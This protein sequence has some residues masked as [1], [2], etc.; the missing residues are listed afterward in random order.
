MKLK[1]DTMYLEINGME[2][3]KDGTSY[4]TGI[5]VRREKFMRME[6]KDMKTIN[7]FYKGIEDEERKETFLAEGLSIRQTDGY[8]V[9]V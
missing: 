4:K 2:L 5:L 3:R 7:V 1:A 9:E 8:G 6:Q